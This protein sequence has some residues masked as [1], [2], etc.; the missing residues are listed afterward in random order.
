MEMAQQ[1]IC[2]LGK[3]ENLPSDPRTHVKTRHNT[4]S[5]YPELGETAKGG[6]RLADQLIYPKYQFPGSVRDCLK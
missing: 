3:Q 6:M 1:V 4:V 5:L 2:L